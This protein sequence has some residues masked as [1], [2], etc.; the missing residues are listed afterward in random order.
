MIAYVGIMRIRR[1]AIA[2][3]H[4]GYRRS[5]V[6]TAIAVPI[7]FRQPGSQTAYQAKKAHHHE[8]N[9]PGNPELQHSSLFVA[10]LDHRSLPD[11][12]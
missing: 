2:L 1:R 7:P 4:G 10:P 9:Y 3:G 12:G 8:R 11:Y 5:M 6:P